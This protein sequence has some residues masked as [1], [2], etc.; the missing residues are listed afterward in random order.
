MNVILEIGALV[1][2]SSD[3]NLAFFG[4]VLCLLSTLIESISFVIVKH[5]RGRNPFRGV[6]PL[7]IIKKGFR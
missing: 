6:H 1:L 4:A 2:T 7:D 5:Y 3:N